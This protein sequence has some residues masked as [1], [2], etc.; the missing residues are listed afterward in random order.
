MSLLA[1]GTERN[2][3]MHIRKL[4]WYVAVTGQH[5]VQQIC[6]MVGMP[7]EADDDHGRLA[8]HMMVDRNEVLT[9]DSRSGLRVWVTTRVLT[10]LS[11]SLASTYLQ[12]VY[13]WF[14][15]L[16]ANVQTARQV[17]CLPWT[18]IGTHGSLKPL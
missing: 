14:A 6:S 15:A 12:Q 11:A 9:P 3:T 16:H 17:G 7:G 13:V 8:A 4:C 5:T 18:S 2:A 1:D 10:L